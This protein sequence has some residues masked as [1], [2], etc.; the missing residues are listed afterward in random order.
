MFL[1]HS[2]PPKHSKYRQFGQTFAFVVG[3]GSCRYRR[4]PPRAPQARARPRGLRAAA[5]ARAHRERVTAVDFE[6]RLLDEADPQHARLS[7]ARAEQPPGAV[8][9]QPVVDHDAARDAVE[10][11][12]HEVLA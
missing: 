4:G 1:I 5:A 6:V 3:Y 8:D 10:V 7:R 12:L 11:E 9:R 2:F